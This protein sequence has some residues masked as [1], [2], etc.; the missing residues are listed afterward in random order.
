MVD[1]PSFFDLLDQYAALNATG[2][3]LE[4]FAAVVEFEVFWAPLVAALRRSARGKG[5]RPQFDP[6]MMFKILLRQAFS[7]MSDEATEL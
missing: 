4:R 5:G 1:Q 3:P 2:N 7:P 6:L